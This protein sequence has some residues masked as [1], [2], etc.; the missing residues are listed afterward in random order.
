MELSWK[1]LNI[2]EGPKEFVFDVFL[3]VEGAS[4]NTSFESMHDAASD[5]GVC[6]TINR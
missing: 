3:D 5:H 6:S 1:L 2:K 4:D